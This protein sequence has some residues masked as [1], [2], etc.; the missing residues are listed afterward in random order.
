MLISRLKFGY[1]AEP[2]T[3]GRPQHQHL[4]LLDEIVSCASTVSCSTTFLT[5][6]SSRTKAL[7]ISEFLRRFP[8]V[9]LREVNSTR[10]KLACQHLEWVTRSITTRS[11][12]TGTETSRLGFNMLAN[13]YF[14]CL[15]APLLAVIRSSYSLR[16]WWS[17]DSSRTET[18][19]ACGV[20]I[21]VVSGWLTELA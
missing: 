18:H 8:R 13:R 11:F 7:W 4:T 5:L 1:W 16:V 6:T 12:S 10:E 21:A 14:P 3:T 20:A 17:V 15:D 19:L 2:S 9:L